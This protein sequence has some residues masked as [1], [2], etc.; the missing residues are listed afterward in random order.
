MQIKILILVALIGL[1]LALT[2]HSAKA[3]KFA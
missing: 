1:T 2:T 3:D